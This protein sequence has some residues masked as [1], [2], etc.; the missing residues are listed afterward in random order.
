[1][2]QHRTLIAAHSGC[3]GTP[4]NS[5]AFMTFALALD[6]DAIE[7][8]VRMDNAGRLVM[9]HDAGDPPGC[10]ETALDMLRGCPGKK[11]NCDLKQ[12]NLE[13][14]VWALAM[15]KG[16]A[17][18]LLYSGEVSRD[19]MLRNTGKAAWYLNIERLFPERYH[20]P[21]LLADEAFC[22][23]VVNKVT[24]EIAETQADCLNICY[25][26][27]DSVLGSLL[28][29]KRVPLSVWTPSD[30]HEVTY[31]IKEGVYSLTT[32]RAAFACAERAR[33]LR[34]TMP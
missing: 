33:F 21:H 1:M 6:V 20:Q 22:R 18:Q 19:W 26:L 29:A 7:V 9:A 12:D 4:D 25:K 8:D 15:S 13:Q 3:D 32:R 24:A 11:M 31:F 14:A 30:D 16:V 5:I 2:A 28:R 34:G 17:R 23:E 10:F 27:Y